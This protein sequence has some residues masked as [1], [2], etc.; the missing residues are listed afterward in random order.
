MCTASASGTPQ[1]ITG[2]DRA[3]R[4]MESSAV[5]LMDKAGG[6]CKPR[7]AQYSRE[8]EIPRRLDT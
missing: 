8:L 7:Q 4:K 3:A 6:A 2:K 5:P 1:T